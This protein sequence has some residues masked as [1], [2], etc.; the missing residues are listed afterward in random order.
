MGHPDKRPE[1][2]NKCI[3]DRR[4]LQQPHFPERF[5]RTGLFCLETAQRLQSIREDSCARPPLPACSAIGKALLYSH[6]TGSMIPILSPTCEH[7]GSHRDV[8]TQPH[9]SATEQRLLGH[10]LPAFKAVPTS[11]VGAFASTTSHGC[12]FV[13][14]VPGLETMCMEHIPSGCHVSTGESTFLPAAL[15]QLRSC[16]L[17]RYPARLRTLEAKS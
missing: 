8:L 9:L 10:N 15:S 14:C 1:V 16:F 5:A 12:V 2:C 7:L 6:Q 17:H 13:P 4:W 11:Q 3:T